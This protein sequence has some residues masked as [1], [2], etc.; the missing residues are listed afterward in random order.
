MRR[1]HPGKGPQQLDGN[2]GQ[3]LAPW[4]AA[5]GRRRQRHR[6]VE[7]RPGDRAKDQDQHHQAATGG[8]TIGKQ[9]DS[10]IPTRQALAHDAGADHDRQ[11]KGSAKTLCH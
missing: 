10:D 9:S 11:K 8:E 6:R 7:M 2:I 1:R 3:H 4:K 5:L